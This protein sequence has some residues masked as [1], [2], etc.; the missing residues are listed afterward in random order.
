MI[1]VKMG[2]QQNIDLLQ[3]GD[4]RRRVNPFGVAIIRSAVGRIDQKRFAGR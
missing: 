1:A 3:P 2:G 4:L